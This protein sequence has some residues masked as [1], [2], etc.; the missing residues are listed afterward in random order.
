MYTDTAA[1][2]PVQLKVGVYVKDLHASSADQRERGLLQA[3]TWFSVV[4]R[5]TRAHMGCPTSFNKCSCCTS[6]PDLLK[7]NAQRPRELQL[8]DHKGLAEA[9]DDNFES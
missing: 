5:H 1:L 8:R 4:S 9:A 2:A 3:G 7:H 6:I